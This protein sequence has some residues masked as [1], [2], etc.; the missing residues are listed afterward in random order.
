MFIFVAWGYDHCEQ[1][2]MLDSL[3]QGLSL[4]VVFYENPTQASNYSAERFLL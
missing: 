3:S 4:T 2:T 1:P